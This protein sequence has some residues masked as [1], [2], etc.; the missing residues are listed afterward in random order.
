MNR[1]PSPHPQDFLPTIYENSSY[2]PSCRPQP[3]YINS[4][5]GYLSKQ[6][7]KLFELVI[8]LQQE[9]KTLKNKINLIE[10]NS[11]LEQKQ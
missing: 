2:T 11:T 4:S 5:N 6:V 9:V 8:A 3:V 1:I 7:D 10:N